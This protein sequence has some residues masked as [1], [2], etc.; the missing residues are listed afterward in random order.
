MAISRRKKIRDPKAWE[1]MAAYFAFF[2]F[3]KDAPTVLRR[4]WPA[5]WRFQVVRRHLLGWVNS[6]D[7]WWSWLFAGM[8]AIVLVRILWASEPSDSKESVNEDVSRDT[9][10]RETIEATFRRH[11]LIRV[12]RSLGLVLIREKLLDGLGVGM[13]AT[14]PRRQFATPEPAP[15]RFDY[16]DRITFTDGRGFEYQ[17]PRGWGPVVVREHP[18]D[19]SQYGPPK[20]RKLTSREQ[21]VLL[22]GSNFY[23]FWLLHRVWAWL[24]RR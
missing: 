20:P 21:M 7:F 12:A 13:Y 18:A 6:G 1:K 24:F 22:I 19:S 16:I 17:Y 11:R 4:L 5:P 23:P 3:L 9:K 15:D 8:T 14:F 2:A 10:L